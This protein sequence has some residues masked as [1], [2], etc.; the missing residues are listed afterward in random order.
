VI[1][2]ASARKGRFAAMLVA[3]LMGAP[4]WAQ[5][6]SPSP[7]PSPSPGLSKMK[8]FVIE[9]AQ[10]D[11]TFLCESGAVQSVLA[12]AVGEHRIVSVVY[13]DK[14]GALIAPD[15]WS[16]A[17]GFRLLHPQ[18]VKIEATMFCGG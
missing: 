8:T 7:S 10:S 5:T 9:P 14:A 3:L 11:Q 13:V 12:F 15:V 6:P 18:T 4:A 1:S 2:F 17:S 16:E